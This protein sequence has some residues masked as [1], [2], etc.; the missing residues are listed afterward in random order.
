MELVCEER[1]SM[2]ENFILTEQMDKFK[3]FYRNDNG[4]FLSQT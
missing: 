1:R 3:R 4:V 2:I